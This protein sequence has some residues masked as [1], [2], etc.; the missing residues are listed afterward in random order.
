MGLF[1]FV[2]DAGKKVFGKKEEEPNADDLL[3]EIKALGLE[4]DGVEVAVDGDKVV[5]GGTVTD[6][7]TKEKIIMAA[8][9][10]EGIAS[11]EDTLE[12]ADPVFHEVKK[13]DT[14]WAISKTALGDGNRYMEIFEANKP[15]LSDP[16]KIYPGQMLIIPQ[17]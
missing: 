10:V 16:D 7:A 3:A 8:G 4:A 5:I 17:G 11:V 15:M 6:Q 13:G 14:L 1:S 12:G 2:K 9:N